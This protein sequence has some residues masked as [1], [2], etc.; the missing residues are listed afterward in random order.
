MILVD[1]VEDNEMYT[2]FAFMGKQLPI[3]SVKR[4]EIIYGPA[5]SLYGAN[6]EFIKL[7]NLSLLF[8]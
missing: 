5:S 6:N 3:Q 1:G 8:I 4:V 2:Q 7:T